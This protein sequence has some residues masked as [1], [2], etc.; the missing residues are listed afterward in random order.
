MA[1]SRSGSFAITSGPGSLLRLDFG[2]G[3]PG[4]FTPTYGGYQ[5]YSCNGGFPALELTLDDAILMRVD[6]F[7]VLRIDP[8]TL[9]TTGSLSLPASVQSSAIR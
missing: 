5:Y 7:G 9:A 2:T 6:Q 8:T 4:S 3:P 1:L